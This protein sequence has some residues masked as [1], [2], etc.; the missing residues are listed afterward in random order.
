MNLRAELE[1]RVS[2][3]LQASGVDAPA[4]VAP[5]A[6]PEFGDYQANGIM[7]A[8]K[9]AGMKPRALAEAVVSA[10]Q[11]DDLAS[12]VEI[13]GPGFI[14]I[15]LRPDYLASL[16]SSEQ[17]LVEPTST[18]DRVVIDY[19]SVNLAK[20]MHVGHL[21]STIIGDALALLL[22][23]L[24]HEVI[25]QNH[26]GDW[27]TQFGM[28]LAFLE[29]KGEDSEQLA[30]LEKFYVAAKKRFDQDADFADRARS[31]VVLLQGGDPDSKRLW[32]R[33]IAVSIAHCNEIYQR[34]GV[35][36]R[37]EHIMPESAYNA[38]LSVVI[39]ELRQQGLLSED[40][41][42][43]CV[44]LD[45]FKGRDDKPLPVIVQKS[46]GGYLYATTDLAALRYRVQKLGA[47]RILVVVG[48]EQSLH[49]QQVFAVG[50]AAGYADDETRLEHITFGNMLG[51]D[52][53]KFSTRAGGVMKLS[54]LLDEAEQRATGLVA[55]KNPDMDAAE[56]REV[57]RVVG[58]GAL[59]YADLSKNRTS[60]YVFDWDQMLSFEGNT[61]P[62]LQYAYTRI[63]SLLRRGGID[64][65]KLQ[66][67]PVLT[68]PAEV[69]LALRLARLQEVLE[70]AAADAMPSHLCTYL[71]EL[72]SAYMSFYEQCPV[73]SADAKVRDSRLLLCRRTMQT[74][75]QGL[76]VLGIETIERM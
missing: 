56:C 39:E 61:A 20:E 54:D 34:L 57:A 59:K 73:L 15:H 30:D 55:E 19:S 6:R 46:D 27:G 5:A 40:Q 70:Q 9:R 71:Y 43:Q 35:T 17:P 45:A 44:F 38:D 25:R 68:E 18:P 48:A 29:E 23:A 26:V 65:D 14:N 69:A 52:G 24:G 16:L 66:G 31:K 8:A 63:R 60:N 36:L 47:N 58:L 10:A 3:A 74:L 53:K 11:L 37:D 7:G 21:R 22:E 49:F 64:P 42:A 76:D 50:R 4:Q 2:A 12:K 33:F 67:Q 72:A 32:Q 75:K 1:Q 41:G 51:P 13:A 62:Y 28:L